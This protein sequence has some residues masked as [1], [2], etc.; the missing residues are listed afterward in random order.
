M[1]R[2]AH[3]L[4][5]LVRNFSKLDCMFFDIET[6]TV[7]ETEKQKIQDFKLGY[8][9]TNRFNNL[10][11]RIDYQS[12]EIYEKGMLL[13]IVWTVIN[14][15]RTLN[16][17]TA[18]IWFDLRT[19]R[20]INALLDDG[21]EVTYRY[22]KGLCCIIKMRLGEYRIQCLNINQFFHTSVEE[23][24]EMLGKPKLSVDFE[25]VSDEKLM[26]YCQRDTEI[27]ADSFHGWIKFIVEHDLGSFGLT[28]ASQSFIAFRHRFMKKKIYVHADEQFTD[29]ERKA[30]YGG[31]TE[32][33]YIG[34]VPE[35]KIY[36]LDINSMYPWVMKT[37]QIPY[38]IVRIEHDIKPERLYQLMDKYFCIAHVAIW[39][40]HPYYPVKTK[41]R[42][43]FP[44]GKF[45]T[46]LCNPELEV[47]R[48]NNHIVYSSCVLCYQSD[49][50]FYDYVNFFHK[51]RRKYKQDGNKVYDTITKYFLTNLYGKFGQKSDMM[52]LKEQVEDKK[53]SVVTHAD[54]DTNDVFRE[55]Y[56]G[57]LHT[58]HKEAVLEAQHAFPA[59]SAA[60]TSYARVRL[61]QLAIN[62]GW[63]NVYYCD[64]DS[65]YVNRRGKNRL[66]SFMHE[67]KL[68]YLKVEKEIKELIIHGA[69]DYNADGIETIKG[70]PKK[71]IKVSS[72]E[73]DMIQFP[74]MKRGM[75][76]GIENL[77]S[78][79]KVNKTLERIYKK[80]VVGKTGRV[81]SIEIRE[82]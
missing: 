61:L 15:R 36:A 68:G 82:W 79:R 73:Y 30:Y 37:K 8:A 9:I 44:T 62:A 60:V 53:F 42:L 58:I 24:G 19:S 11:E 7:Q 27:I 34:K 31:R 67:S 74:S 48:L 51:L 1:T 76:E 50:I 33:F 64:T 69:K 35:K 72:N 80:G 46:I 40:E 38:K 66:K 16:I 21:F 13:D 57:G 28:V 63:T 49:L 47:A 18:N 22:T 6:K 29:V 77:Y 65:L 14:N 70:I 59:V 54:K 17:L 26:I 12:Y 25:N 32:A 2:Q 23:M 10:G 75:K 3:I 4:T 52:L 39:T 56:F 81:T 20:L 78:I 45:H 55:S 5:N 71:A 41:E 43:L